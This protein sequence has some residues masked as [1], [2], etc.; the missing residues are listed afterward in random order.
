MDPYSN[1]LNLKSALSIG[2]VNS[3]MAILAFNIG[4]I[5]SGFILDFTVYVGHLITAFVGLKLILETNK[6]EIGKREFL[7]EDTPILFGLSFASSF[8]T[9]LVFLGFGLITKEWIFWPPFI[10]IAVTV[11]VSVIIGIIIG[12]K[13]RPKSFGRHIKFIGGVFLI[14]LSA[15]LIFQ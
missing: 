6:N 2:F 10:I 8:N 12:N 13:Y 15:F 4:I 9:F 5:I 1:W 11:F 3:L 7:V 14:L